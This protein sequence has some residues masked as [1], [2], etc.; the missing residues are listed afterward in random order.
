LSEEKPEKSNNN[1]PPTRKFAEPDSDSRVSKLEVRILM[2]AM[3]L[4]SSK[5]A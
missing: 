4:A 1:D 5:S 2:A 3:E